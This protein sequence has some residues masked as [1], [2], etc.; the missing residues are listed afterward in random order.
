MDHER[1]DPASVCLFTFELFLQWE[2]RMQWNYADL[3]ANLN[4]H[5]NQLQPRLREMSHSRAERERDEEEHITM[6][7][8]NG[9]DE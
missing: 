2:S 3:R 4:L 9:M 1:G 5:E 8:Q 7:Q 6:K